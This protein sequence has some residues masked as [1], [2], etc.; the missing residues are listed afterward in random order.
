M[1]TIT[2]PYFTNANEIE[3]FSS[4][5]IV[6]AEEDPTAWE[7]WEPYPKDDDGPSEQAKQWN[8]ARLYKGRWHWC[9]GSMPKWFAKNTI[10]ATA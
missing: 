2:D 8:K 10:G 9:G 6:Q 7:P 4:G 1:S 3:E 5:I